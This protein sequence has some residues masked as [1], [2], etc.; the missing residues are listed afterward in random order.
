MSMI[1]ATNNFFII[2]YCIDVFYIIFN[3]S[4]LNII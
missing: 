3:I 1:C 2:N 4:R